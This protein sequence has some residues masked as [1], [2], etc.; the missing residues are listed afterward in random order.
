MRKEEIGF[1]ATHPQEL[2]KYRGEW[3][4]VVGDKIIAHGKDFK[5]VDDEARKI[6]PNPVFDKIPKED[7]V[8]Y[9]NRISIS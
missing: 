6:S 9:A 1:L 2:S 3:I 5:K 8:V 4:A 7:V